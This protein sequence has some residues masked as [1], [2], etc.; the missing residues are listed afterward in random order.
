MFRLRF[1][2]A[3]HD[4][5]RTAR[6]ASDNDEA[7]MTDDEIMSNDE[8][9][10]V[11]AESRFVIRMSSFLRHFSKPRHTKAASDPAHLRLRECFA[12]LDCTLYAAQDNFLEKLDVVRIDNLLINFD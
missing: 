11:R 2:S 3:Q 4:K 7:G 10:I 8:A 12:L 6:T 9:R 1:C 5:L